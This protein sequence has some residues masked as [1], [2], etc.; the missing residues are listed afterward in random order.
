MPV[1]SRKG[2][3]S[4][5]KNAGMKIIFNLLSTLF[6]I[7]NWQHCL[8]LKTPYLNVWSK[9]EIK[10]FHYHINGLFISILHFE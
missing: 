7:N 3:K 6:E 9:T 10:Q 5:K 4:T 8:K 2:N 1:I